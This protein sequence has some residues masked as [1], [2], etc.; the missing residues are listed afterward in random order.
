[1][2]NKIIIREFKLKNLIDYLSAK[3]KFG[4]YKMRLQNLQLMQEED[5]SK[6]VY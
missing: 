2:V 4:K 1:M 6:I 3:K 5:I